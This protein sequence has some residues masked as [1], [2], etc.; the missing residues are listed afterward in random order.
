MNLEQ[1][2][3]LIE[4][5]KEDADLNEAIYLHNK[6]IEETL[7][8]ETEALKMKKQIFDAKLAAFLREAGVPEKFNLIDLMLKVTGHD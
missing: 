3:K 6:K 1:R 8:E 2:L 5:S 4:L 7:K